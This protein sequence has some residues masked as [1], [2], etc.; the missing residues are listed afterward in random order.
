[1]SVSN[2][3]QTIMQAVKDYIFLNHMFPQINDII[4]MTG[5]K[6]G[7]D[8]C[9]KLIAQKKLYACFT[10]PTLPTII[11]PYDMMQLILLTQKKPD[12]ASEHSFEERTAVDR[13]I[14]EL[15]SQIIKYDMFER[16]LYT[17]D[18]PLEEAVAYTLD[19]LGFENVVHLKEDTDNA[20]I[21][22]SFDGTKNLIEVEGTT[23]QGGKDKVNQ[24]NGWIKKELETTDTEPEKLKGFFVVN[25]FRETNLKDRGIPLS[26]HAK[27][28]MK[29]H[30]FGFFTTKF[31]FECVKDVVNG[32]ITK[33][34]AQKL[35]YEGEQYE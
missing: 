15:N 27:K 30:K 7:D 12:W 32:K 35:I 19:F 20:D 28:F 10:G 3:D 24:L 11:L 23:N 16:L 21:S 29:Y 17:T 14:E 4:K 2:E 26:L 5:I 9:K 1:M 31:L 33:D 22:F 34:D 25:H 13:K 8:V 18:K 6:K